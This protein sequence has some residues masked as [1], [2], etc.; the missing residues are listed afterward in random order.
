M[1]SPGNIVAALGTLEAMWSGPR[2]N[3]PVSKKAEVQEEKSEWPGAVKRKVRYGPIRLPPTSEP[4]LESMIMKVQGMGYG[5]KMNARKPCDD[6]CTILA[7]QAT[8]EF[9]DGS[10]A[11][12]DKGAWFHHSTLISAGPNART[13]T[14]GWPVPVENLFMS[15]N[16]KSSV[17]FSLPANETGVRSGYH[18]GPYETFVL[19]AKLMNLEDAEKFVWITISYDVLPGDLKKEIKVGRML[20]QSLDTSDTSMCTGAVNPF[21]PLNVTAMMQPIRRRFSEHTIPWTA[22]N[23]GTILLTG[24]HMH[25]GG[26]SVDTVHNGQTICESVAQYGR[27]AGNAGSEGPGHG[28]HSRRQIPA[29]DYNNMD[30]DHILEQ[31]RCIYSKGRSLKKGDKLWIRANYDFDK[32]P[33]MKNQKG[34]LDEIMGIVGTL[35]AT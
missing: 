12:N 1:F 11:E 16:E 10:P 21:G 31:T 3:M 5:F 22:P 32:H 30:I 29:G 26:I 23:D 33:G 4:N 18:I 17:I 24:G 34:E 19:H 6:D 28:G 9:A 8:L 2:D 14:C 35:I 15:G 7:L 27:R 13:I 25:D 20:W